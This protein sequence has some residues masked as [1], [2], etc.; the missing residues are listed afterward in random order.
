ME[1]VNNL[2]YIVENFNS[3]CLVQVLFLQNVML[4]SRQMGVSWTEVM[5]G[6]T[7]QHQAQSWYLIFDF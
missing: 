4:K 5:G 7:I 1:P 3:F 2:Y 6:I